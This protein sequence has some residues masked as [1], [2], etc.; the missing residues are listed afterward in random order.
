MGVMTMVGPYER[1]LVNSTTGKV[2][3]F[4]TNW[5]GNRT[6]SVDMAG[7]CFH[8]RVLAERKPR[9]RDD[10]R[11]NLEN[12]FMEQ[13][14]DSLEHLEPLDNCTKLYSWHVRTSATGV[15]MNKPLSVGRDPEFKKLLPAV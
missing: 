7:F 10:T 6:Y 15:D 12:G 3:G 2:Q 1:C 11:G 8:S 4:V 5:K 13:L 9:F 14:V